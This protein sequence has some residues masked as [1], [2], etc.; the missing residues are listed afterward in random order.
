M[1]CNICNKELKDYKGLA[2]HLR[3]KHPNQTGKTYYDKF[4]KNPNE[5]FCRLETCNKKCTYIDLRLGYSKHCCSK[6]SG[7][8]KNTKNVRAKTNKKKFGVKFPQNLPEFRKKQET[9]MMSKYGC[10][11][12]MGSKKIRETQKQSILKK[13][14]VDNISQLPE[15]RK[16]AT[17]KM[18]K[19]MIKKGRWI[20]NSQLSAWD[21]YKRKVRQLTNH[22]K[23]S[24]FSLKQLSRTGR[25]GV[26]NALQVDHIYSIK[27]GFLDQKE[28]EWISR[29]DNL[30]LIPWEDNLDKRL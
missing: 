11:T 19:T 12:P 1:K 24:K 28:P 22:T 6:H 18:K 10:K 13:Y 26:P 16:K 8:D 25:C 2:C 23:K 21:K 3:Y 30:Q 9:T 20:P 4:L 14:G 7:I 17:D 15:N 27:E 29:M 5:G